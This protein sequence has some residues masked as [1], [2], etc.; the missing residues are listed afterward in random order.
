MRR[1]E[2]LNVPKYA[3]RFLPS[4]GSLATPIENPKSFLLPSLQVI[5]ALYQSPDQ[6][7]IHRV[8]AIAVN[9]LFASP[10]LRSLAEGAYPQPDRLGHLLSQACFRR[11]L[12]S[13]PSRK[14]SL[15]RRAASTGSPR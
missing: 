11:R 4:L 14:S 13:P 12:E 7:R 1:S 6:P 5:G 8:G 15:F 2:P 9:P 3:S 10:L